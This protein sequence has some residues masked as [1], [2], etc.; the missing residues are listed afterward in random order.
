MACKGS[1]RVYT[2]RCLRHRHHEYSLPASVPD[3]EDQEKA[4]R[5]RALEILKREKEE[6]ERADRQRALEIVAANMK[7][8]L[9]AFVRLSFSCSAKSDM[10]P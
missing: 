8:Y 4:D 10:L 3:E 9:C 6:Q 2:V 7:V 5:A 1:G